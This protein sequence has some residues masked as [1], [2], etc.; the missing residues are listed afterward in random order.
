MKIENSYVYDS[1]N[2]YRYKRK[3]NKSETVA[4]IFI[5]RIFNVLQF[6]KGIMKRYAIR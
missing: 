5:A 4:I 1:V 6:D 3:L 2:L